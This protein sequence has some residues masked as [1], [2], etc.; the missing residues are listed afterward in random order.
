MLGKILGK[1]Y[2]IIKKIGGGGMAEVYKAR[3]TLLN[4][5]VAVKVLRNEFR[6]DKEFIARFNTEAQ[7]AASLTHPNIVS[8]YDVGYEDGIHYIVMEFVE[9]ITLKEYIRQNGALSW[10]QALEFTVQI[11]RAIDFA[12]K[13]GII[14]RDIKPQNIMVCE[15][16]VLKV[17]DFGIA[18]NLN[19]NG[20]TQDGK[21]AMGTV[22]Y[23]SPEQA[24]GGYVDEK[25]DIYSIGVV[26]YEMM[27]GRLP[28]NHE[29]PV[30]VAIMH[31]QQKPV[32]PREIVLSIPSAL[33][34][35]C[36]KAMS[37]EQAQRFQT[38][39]EMMDCLE[40]LRNHQGDSNLSH[41]ENTFVT[42][43]YDVKQ[44]KKDEEVQ[45]MEM[46]RKTE[47]DNRKKKPSGKKSNGKK[48]ENKKPMI[49][50]IISAVAVVGILTLLLIRW[51]DPGFFGGSSND[52]ITRIPNLVGKDLEK[53]LE[54]YED[55]ERVEIV[56]EKDRVPSD[57]YGEGVITAQSPKAGEKA[58]NGKIKIKVIVSN[59]EKEA[60]KMP[61]LSGKTLTDAK[62][63]LSKLGLNYEVVKEYSDSVT[64]N[65]IIRQIPKAGTTV[66]EDTQI[67][68]YVSKGKE[69][70][71]DDEND[72]E[73]EEIF[74]PYLIGMSQ[75][76]AK[77]ALKEA[78]LSLGSVTVKDSDEPVGT[79]IGQNPGYQETVEG[80]TAVGII[81]S[82]GESGE[83]NIPEPSDEPAVSQEPMETPQPEEPSEPV[84]VTPDP[85]EPDVSETTVE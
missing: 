14:H 5:Y 52:G 3:C 45:H 41:E 71:E 83:I 44:M 82:S 64:R 72:D 68:L 81:I 42:K 7:A 48:Q 65:G 17:M 2:Q 39:E 80:G 35:I 29:N 33:E 49:A 18:R 76:Q 21:N 73:E 50:A 10:R 27:T 60:G 79:V 23:I 13:K 22:H 77:N 55:E 74:V 46:K 28:F 25:T 63:E 37:K 47:E 62:R 69:N 66:D 38:V 58:G 57:K 36:L 53:V 67:V 30:S 20:Q 59:G 6:E 15:N 12:H 70:S 61:N 43:K 9:G 16:D 84:V 32:A 8:V 51:I 75:T 19:K 34:D 85:I 54:E 40:R 56:E 4:R 78:G 26:L 11:C 24:R 31:M 1:R